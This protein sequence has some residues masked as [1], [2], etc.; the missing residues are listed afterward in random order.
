MDF[1]P[2]MI[3]N[4]HSIEEAWIIVTDG[5]VRGIFGKNNPLKGLSIIY[6]Y[7]RRIES[8]NII[9]VFPSHESIS[10]WLKIRLEP[11]L[12]DP[13]LMPDDDV[14]HSKHFK[15]SMIWRT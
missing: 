11:E 2:I 6:S 10:K 3:G 4:G 15:V 1:Q 7:D 9:L 13:V 5:K 8:N 12:H 14:A